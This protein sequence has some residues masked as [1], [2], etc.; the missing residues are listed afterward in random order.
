MSRNHKTPQSILTRRAELKEE[1]AELLEETNSDFSVQDIID[2]I[3]NEEESD[4]FQ[5][6]IAMFDDGNMDNLSNT[7]ELATDA[8]NYFPHKALKGKSPQEMILQ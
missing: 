5:K 4:D 3:N 7:L 1:L 8:W 2:I 6:I